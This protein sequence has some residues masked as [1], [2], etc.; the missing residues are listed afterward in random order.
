M[1]HE[2]KKNVQM[3]HCWNVLKKMYFKEMIYYCE[4]SKTK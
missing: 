1:T 3:I 2:N 4:Y